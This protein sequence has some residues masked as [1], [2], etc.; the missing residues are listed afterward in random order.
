MFVVTD[1]AEWAEENFGSCELGDKRRYQAHEVV[2]SEG[3]DSVVERMRQLDA[4]AR[5]GLINGE[6][7]QQKRD[8]NLRAL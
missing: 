3:G 5:E 4:L 7:Y 6:E 2:Q 1:A 8:E